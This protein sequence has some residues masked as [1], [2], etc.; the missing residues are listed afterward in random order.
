MGLKNHPGD[1]DDGSSPRLSCLAMAQAAQSS[2]EDCCMGL[3]LDCVPDLP[4][5]IRTAADAGYR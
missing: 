3:A 2:N 4:E 5:A 1:D